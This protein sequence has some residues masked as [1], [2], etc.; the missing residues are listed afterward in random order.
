MVSISKHL[1]KHY[2]LYLII[3]VAILFVTI[4]VSLLNIEQKEI[5][6]KV[7]VQLEVLLTKHAEKTYAEGQ[8]DAINGDVRLDLLNN[9]WIKSPWDNKDAKILGTIKMCR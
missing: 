3:A 2:P 7:T 4:M 1:N 8:R 6:Q 5:K 9:C